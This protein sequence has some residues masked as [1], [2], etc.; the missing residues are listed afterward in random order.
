M[1][2]IAHRGNYSGSNKEK[3][4]SIDYII[5]AI[6]NGYDVEIDIRKIDNNLYLGHDHPQYIVN[7]DFLLNYSQFLWI[8][9]KNIEALT[10]L[11]NYN[12]LNIFGHDYD[13]YVLTS[14]GF[15]WCFPGKH[16]TT[17]SILVMPE[18]NGIDYN[19]LDSKSFYGVCSDILI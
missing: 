15:I 19:T 18:K 8:H 2:L 3:E 4:N 12:E 6:K 5:N 17:R 10:Y 16:L 11:I 14:K 9:C 7:L 13:E 1:K